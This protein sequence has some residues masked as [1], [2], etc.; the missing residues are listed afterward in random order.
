MRCK[1]ERRALFRGLPR[2]RK[3]IYRKQKLMG[4]FESRSYAEVAGA[5]AER[6]A[7][8]LAI[9]YG[10]FLFVGLFAAVPLA[11][12]IVNSFNMASPGHPFTPGVD[13]WKEAFAD[14][15]TLS[16]VGY[17][18]LLSIRSLVGVV[19]SFALA[20]L[21]V[22]IQIPGRSVIE[23]FLWVAFF[24]PTLPLTLGWILLLDP[25]YGLINQALLS[26]PFVERAP[27]NIYSVAGILW[28]H[29]TLT[30]VPVM[31]ILLIP[32][33]TQFDAAIEESS[34]VSGAG[35]WGTLRR[36]TFPLLSPAILTVVIA[37][38]IR[39]LEAFEIEQVLGTPAGIGVYATR[40]YDLVS[41]EPP[42][43]PGAMALST[44]F[45]GVLLLLALFY[46]RFTGQR[47]YVTVTARGLS[48]R[49]LAVG[50]WRYAVSFG[51]FA[52][53]VTGVILPLAMLLLGSFM[54]LYGFFAVKSPL[55]VQHWLSASKDPLF[56][57]SLKNS[58]IIGLGVAAIGV[59][60]YG[61]IAYTITRTRAPLRSMLSVLAWLPW[62]VPG[63]LLGVALLWL[64]LSLPLVS[65][66]YGTLAPI[67][68]VLVVKEMPIGTHL[69]KTALGQI[70]RELE[71]ASLACGAHRFTTFWRI[72]VPLI[73]P[74]VVSIF[75][76][77]FVAA[78]RDISTT[79]LLVSAR[80]RSLSVLML[81]YSRGGQLEIASIMGVI[82]ATVSIAVALLARR[83][84]LAIGVGS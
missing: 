14:D 18:V 59:I 17:S 27:L 75:S 69:M 8:D 46:Q 3:D 11:F 81:E 19:V 39:S 10:T 77:V 44:F 70:S 57:V 72:T 24:L 48:L 38:L 42:R 4:I 12:V 30:T 9:G 13:G 43:F 31:T 47:E 37:G 22:R 50:R 45:L 15:K 64:L 79:I 35:P 55:T 23:F 29:M 1:T 58:L 76:I 6:S 16:A 82:I 60:G 2:C 25:N 54:R 51:C 83:L 84:G 56:L 34:L 66:L 53:I 21:L 49:P 33:L 68:L 78:I 26:L 40:I 63:I 71:E 73:A 7:S 28:V 67:I 74:T 65:L 52:W 62:A 80:T 41:W 61:L 32:A 20:W 36:I 5:A